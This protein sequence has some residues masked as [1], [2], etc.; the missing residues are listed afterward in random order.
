M[1]WQDSVTLFPCGKEDLLLG[2]DLEGE[3]GDAYQ[4][5][6]KTRMRSLSYSGSMSSST[7]RI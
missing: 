1:V 7:R 2:K 5:S 6:L 4:L 3:R